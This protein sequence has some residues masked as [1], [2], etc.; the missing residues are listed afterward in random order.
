[1]KVYVLFRKEVNKV[2][3]DVCKILDFLSGPKLCV[4]FDCLLAIPIFWTAVKFSALVTGAFLNFAESVKIKTALKRPG[5]FKN[6]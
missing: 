4:S 3:K 6:Y 2:T 1:M 5:P